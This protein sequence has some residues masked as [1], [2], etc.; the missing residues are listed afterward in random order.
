M[1]LNLTRSNLRSY[2]GFM[3]GDT[4]CPSGRRGGEAR[5]SEDDD[6]DDDHDGGGG[7]EWSVGVCPRAH[8]NRRNS[9]TAVQQSKKAGR[10][11]G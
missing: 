9:T 4:I 5:V 10:R 8:N 1:G 11:V 7:H 2:E 6:D 3:N